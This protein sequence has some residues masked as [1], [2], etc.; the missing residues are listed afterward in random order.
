MCC[1]EASKYLSVFEE[2]YSSK[3]RPYGTL[4]P[5]LRFASK[6]EECSA[7]VYKFEILKKEQFYIDLYKPVLN[8]NPKA[9]ASLFYFKKGRR[10]P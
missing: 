1:L 5:S 2:K 7:F 4:G 9:G 10:S 6:T 8:L 3:R